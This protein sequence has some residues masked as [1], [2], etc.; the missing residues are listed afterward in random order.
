MAESRLLLTA[1]AALLVLALGLHWPRLTRRV[2]RAAWA[3][4]G[5]GALLPL[6]DP[7][8]SRLS[9]EDQIAALTGMPHF[10]GPLASFGL[11][12]LVSMAVAIWRGPRPA[13]QVL[14]ALGAGLALHLLLM[15]LT[16]WGVP[17]LAPFAPQ[18][19]GWGLLPQGHGLLIGLLAAGVAAQEL[20]PTGGRAVRWG[21]CAATVLYGAAALGGYLWADTRF[22]TA[23]DANTRRSIEP[24][25]IWPV[26]WLIIDRVPGNFR[27]ATVRW[28]EAAPEKPRT[29]ARWN[30]EPLFLA[31]MGD[32]VVYRL[33]TLAFLHPVV[34]L[35]ASG[36]QTTLSMQELSEHVAGTSG[37]RFVFTSDLAGRNRLYRLER[38]D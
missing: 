19:F 13:L 1:T 8:L 14:G 34:E 11:A 26:A 32:P 27:V 36:S 15:A 12:G 30:D 6:L 37:P 23:A 24:A 38:F 2:P 3:L 9:G 21:V 35:D 5:S 20:W 25:S 17:V 16:P 7:V 29:I 33:Y 31:E 28:G 4:A 18:R 10:S 22:P